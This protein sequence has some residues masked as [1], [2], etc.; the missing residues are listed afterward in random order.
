MTSVERR[1]WSRLRASR[2]CGLKFQAQQPIGPYIADFYCSVARI[3]IELDGDAHSFTM[4]NDQARQAYLEELGITVI[5]FMNYDVLH[6][7]DFVL[8]RIYEHCKG[9][10]PPHD[11]H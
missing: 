5:R 9:N 1:L 7:A 2:F 3:V 6:S 10:L 8:E 11:E 4:K